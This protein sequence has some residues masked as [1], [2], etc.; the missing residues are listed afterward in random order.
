MRFF[1]NLQC[2]GQSI[3]DDEGA[4]SESPASAYSDALT[5]LEEFEED[6]AFWEGWDLEIAD[7]AGCTIAVIH[8]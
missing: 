4:E 6:R 8:L 3:W 7:A 2:E 5:A 1:F